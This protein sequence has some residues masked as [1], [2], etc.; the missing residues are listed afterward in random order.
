MPSRKQPTNRPS[1][2]VRV[3][4]ISAAATLGAALIAGAFLLISRDTAPPEQPPPANAT[5]GSPTSAVDLAAIEASL[6]SKDQ[7]ARLNGL[8]RL[9]QEK[10][11]LSPSQRQPATNALVRFV[12]MR[13]FEL[14][15]RSAPQRA[16]KLDAKIP[17][18]PAPD[19]LKT[20]FVVLQDLRTLGGTTVNLSALPMVRVDLTGVDFSG[21]DL[22]NV[23]LMG[24]RMDTA[25]FVGADLTGS[26]LRGSFCWQADFRQASLHDVNLTSVGLSESTLI[27]AKL[28][29]ANLSG[30]DLTGADVSGAD[31]TDANLIGT[32]LSVRSHDGAIFGSRLVCNDRTQWPAGFPKPTCDPT[33]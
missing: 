10:E 6:N 16:E 30:A 15:G 5:V 29:T 19:D 22:R 8:T 13:A 21:M 17:M 4:R 25:K 28:T 27:G 23:D 9:A 3:A 2:A 26:W 12:R 31:F 20:A 11:G 33:W 18:R 14:T 32:N 1:E 24:S 7:A